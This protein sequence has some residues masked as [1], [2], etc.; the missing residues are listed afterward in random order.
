MNV[1]DIM[2][3]ITMLFLFVR[4]LMRGFVRE[5]ASL[6]GVILG[7]VLAI[8]FQPQASTFIKTFLPP[9][10]FLPLLAFAGIFLVVLIVCNLLGWGFRWLFKKALLGWVDRTLGVGLAVIKGIILTYLVIVLL[11]FFLPAQTPLIAQ[12]RLAPEIISSYQYMVGLISPEHYQNLKRK[13]T[14]K[15]REIGGIISGKKSSVTEKP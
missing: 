6:A 1:L 5:I 9:I 3:I 10:S 14:G 2:I 11:T 12:S 13:F 7:I 4:G 15:T 8:R